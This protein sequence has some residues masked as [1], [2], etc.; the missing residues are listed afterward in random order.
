MRVYH[1]TKKADFTEFRR[2]VNFFTD[3]VEVADSYSP[4]SEKYFG[5]LNITNPFTIDAKG[6]KWLSIPID[7]R[8]KQILDQYGCSTF[9]ENGIW[10]TTT[11]DLVSAI[12]DMVDDGVADYDGI[13]VRNVDDVG[14]YWK[15]SKSA[16]AND[17]V[18][19]NS[20]QFKN[21]DNI[22]PT[23][24]KDIRFELKDQPRF[25]IKDGKVIIDTDQ[26]I[27]DS[28]AKSEYGRVARKYIREHFRGKV[29]NDA[30]FTRI[31]ENEYTMSKYTQ[32][33]YNHSDGIFNAKMRASTELD[34]MLRIG[35]Y[36]R[37]EDAKHPHSYNGNGYDRYS[38]SF[39]LDGITFDGQLL[40]AVDSNNKRTFYDIVSIKRTDSPV[41]EALP[42]NGNISERGTIGSSENSIPQNNAN[43]NRKAEKTS[44]EFSQDRGYSRG[45][46]AKI[47]A[48]ATKSKVYSKA[49]AEAAIDNVTALVSD[50]TSEVNVLRKADIRGKS[51]AEVIDYLW[52]R[53]NAAQEKDRLNV[54]LNTAE[55]LINHAIVKEEYDGYGAEG[56]RK[57]PCSRP[58]RTARRGGSLRTR[59][60]LMLPSQNDQGTRNKERSRK[61]TRKQ[62][63]KETR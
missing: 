16:I 40:V 57:R 12:E 59:F 4:N 20:N 25:S 61:G 10:K 53:M 52:E 33:K 39:E 55:Y 17:Y 7:K 41:S 46:T 2:N 63:N 27:F 11:S 8:T 24:S 58:P 56:K 15:S 6:A 47:V 9:S 23:K 43:V 37:H 38:I 49:E 18:I 13:V 22:A 1:G 30:A 34:N 14:Q 3:S 62:G 36:I 50:L 35:E 54:A 32:N 51:R 60:R 5:Y 45:Q 48:N 26:H 44:G 29:I 31:S 19:F 21:A 28:A 42:K